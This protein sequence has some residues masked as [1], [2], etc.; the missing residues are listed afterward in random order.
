L[1]HLLF[2]DHEVESAPR[3]HFSGEL[4]IAL[5]SWRERIAMSQSLDPYH[6][7]LGIPPRLQPPNHYRLLG[8]E[9]FEGNPDVIGDAADRQMAHVRRYEN[10]P[11]AAA[12]QK[13]LAELATAKVCLL[14][15][16]RKSAYDAALRKK[17]ASAKAPKTDDSAELITAPDP[18]ARKSPA[19]AAPPKST[20][21]ISLPRAV[22][23][24]V[25][26][27]QS[28]LPA[29]VSR[30][31]EPY[32][33]LDPLTREPPYLGEYRRRF[34]E[35]LIKVSIFIFVLAL[36]LIL[37]NAFVLPWLKDTNS[38]AGPPI[39]KHP[40]ASPPAKYLSPPLPP[41]PVSSPEDATEEA[42]SSPMLEM[43]MKDDIEIEREPKS[44]SIF[45]TIQTAMHN[46]QIQRTPFIGEESGDAFETK[47]GDGGLL[48]ALKLTWKKFGR[49]NEYRAVSSIQPEYLTSLGYVKG[50]VHGTPE[51]NGMRF[52]AKQGYGI[53]A[54]KVNYSAGGS[55]ASGRIIGLKI[56]FMRL[57][58]GRLN[59]E[60]SY[61]S[62]SFPLDSSVPL[63]APAIGG[64]GE[65][66]VGIHGSAAENGL[67][68]LGLILLQKE[69]LRP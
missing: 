35:S 52:L 26:C 51:K 14:L 54:L 40:V 37:F 67:H 7:F 2:H 53:G 41:P 66:A 43:P 68:S 42:E 3:R 8:L 33:P 24:V 25:G 29:A 60:H 13:L 36:G 6:R 64:D 38:A 17:L 65:L 9:L 46:G 21:E 28:P 5:F 12:A 57:E 69:T 62:S 61:T 30:T 48:V 47:H 63:D 15:P 39:A 19:G 1:H 31:V 11:Y 20:R 10:S 56:V 44:K 23:T 16:E 49:N 22:P 55:R 4:Q 34:F 32:S 18:P 50:S 45:Q 59:P 58:D 27:R